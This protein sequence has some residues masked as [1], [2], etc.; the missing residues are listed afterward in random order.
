MNKI[1]STMAVLLLMA[2]AVPGLGA[3]ATYKGRTVKPDKALCETMA[4]GLPHLTQEV[5]AANATGERVLVVVGKRPKLAKDESVIL[6]YRLADG[7]RGKMV[8]RVIGEVDLAHGRSPWEL[9]DEEQKGTIIIWTETNGG[10]AILLTTDHRVK[11]GEEA[12]IKIKVKRSTP[13]VEGC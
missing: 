4:K 2:L 1:K 6:R 8:A 13:A 12:R 10:K 7:T 5:C 9:K 11:M 3:A